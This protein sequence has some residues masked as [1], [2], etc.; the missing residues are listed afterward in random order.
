MECEI[1][2]QDVKHSDD[3]LNHV[4]PVHPTGVVDTSMKK[5]EKPDHLGEPRKSPRN[6]SPTAH[7][8]AAIISV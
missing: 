1:C 3:L 4:E 2:G 5:L 6:G 8:L 7:A